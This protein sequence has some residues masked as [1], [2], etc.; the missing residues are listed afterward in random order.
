MLPDTR[1]RVLSTRMWGLRSLIR[2]QVP[3][4]IHVSKE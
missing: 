3:S 4:R 2:S 1:V